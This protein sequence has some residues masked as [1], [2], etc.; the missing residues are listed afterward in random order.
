MSTEYILEQSLSSSEA[1]A[2]LDI[3]VDELERRR[4][5]GSLLALWVKTSN[6]WVYPAFQFAPGVS[7]YGLQLL[8]SILASRVGFSPA[9]D[10][11]GWARAFWLFQ[12]RG[13]LS[14]QARATKGYGPMDPVTVL[15]LI[16]D[17]SSA[18]RAPAD[19]FADDPVAVIN[20]AEAL[21]AANSETPTA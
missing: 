18:A 2:R 7:A 1:V 16:R 17:I 3:T 8:L 9:N 15:M 14:L 21:H 11:G 20:L 12:P 5:Q 10:R 4:A 13:E 19:A 6:A